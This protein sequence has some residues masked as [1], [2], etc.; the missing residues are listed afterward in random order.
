VIGAARA[1]LLRLPGMSVRS[2][3]TVD[4]MLCEHEKDTTGRYCRACRTAYMREWRKTHPPS[5]EE[6]R[7]DNCRSY[8]RMLVR[9]GHLIPQPCVFCGSDAEALHLDY[10]RP[11][12][13]VWMCTPCRRWFLRW[14]ETLPRP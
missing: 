11:R 7:K 2:C 3:F 10:D 4:P 5:D 8:T 14:L 1:G 6:R 13:V 9:R 12:L